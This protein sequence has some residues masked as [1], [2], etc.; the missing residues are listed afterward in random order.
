MLPVTDYAD[1]TKTC[2]KYQSEM[3]RVCS[4]NIPKNSLRISKNVVVFF[5]FFCLQQ[6]FSPWR[7]DNSKWLN[8]GGTGVSNSRKIITY[9]L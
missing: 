1:Y 8:H 7:T 9:K 4:R 5:L 2:L 6:D 3:L